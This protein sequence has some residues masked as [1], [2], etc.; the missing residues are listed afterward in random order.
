M[1]NGIRTKCVLGAAALALLQSGSAAIVFDGSGTDG[2]AASASFEIIGKDLQ[3][4]LTNLGTEPTV[5]NW[6]A[7]YALSGLFFNYSGSGSISA[8]SASVGGG[9]IGTTP[10]GKTIGNYWAFD[11]NLTGAPNGATDGLRAA[12]FGVGGGSAYGNLGPAEGKT[13]VGGIDG[14][15]LGWD[16]ITGGNAS[17]KLP[18][19]YDSV[20]FTLTGSGLTSLKASDFSDVTFQYGTAFTEAHFEG[21][22]HVQSDFYKDDM[23]SVPEPSTYI[24]GLSAL[25]ILGLHGWRYRKSR[26]A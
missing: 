3:V 26:A 19:V 16:S 25:G 21:A 6:D 24:A 8:G 10:A 20:V 15:I 2:R 1:T 23:T 14:A 12:G 13:K 22:V 17:L 18:L 7:S 5:K 4:T 9:V 11:S